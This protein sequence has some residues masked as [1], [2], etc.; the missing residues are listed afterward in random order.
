MLLIGF[1]S[2]WKAMGSHGNDLT[3]YL[4]KKMFILIAVRKSIKWGWG[5]GDHFRMLFQ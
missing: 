2:N 4:L 1:S 3:K 5:W